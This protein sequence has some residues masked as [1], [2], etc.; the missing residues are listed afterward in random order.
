MYTN[1]QHFV[2][3]SN[4]CTLSSF[5]LLCTVLYTVIMNVQHRV[6][7]IW[8]QHYIVSGWPCHK[9]IHGHKG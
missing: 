8:V 1:Y 4:I 5:E 9:A 3:D 6:D 2:V 7:V